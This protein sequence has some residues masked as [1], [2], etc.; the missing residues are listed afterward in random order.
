MDIRERGDIQSR[1][2]DDGSMKL[3]NTKKGPG[4]KEK[5]SCF[6][7]FFASVPLCGEQGTGHAKSGCSGTEEGCPQS[8][9]PQSSGGAESGSTHGIIE[10]R[11]PGGT[12]FLS[13]R[14]ETAGRGV[15]GVE[16]LAG[17]RGA[18]LNIT[19][20]GEEA[21]LWVKQQ[22]QEIVRILAEHGLSLEGMTIECAGEDTGK[23]GGRSNDAAPRKT[24]PA[25]GSRG[26]PG[27]PHASPSDVN[28]L[29]A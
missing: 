11:G 10:G 17:E 19:A 14:V 27:G 25:T 8:W 15:L 1:F 24:T 7:A 5:S 4:K 20:P 28:E 23:H 9:H 18:R 21:F 29:I 16:I 3:E 6:S 26:A 12:H 22:E 2:F 13:M